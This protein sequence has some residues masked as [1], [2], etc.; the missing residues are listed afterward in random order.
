M[1]TTQSR[2]ADAQLLGSVDHLWAKDRNFAFE[3]YGG[4]AE[5]FVSETVFALTT[6]RQNYTAEL[7]DL[8]SNILTIF[9]AGVYLFCFRS[10]VTMTGGGAGQVAISLQQDPATGT[11]TSIIS[12]FNYVY[13][14]PALN[15]TCQIVI[16]LLVGFDYRYRIVGIRTSGAGNVQTLNQSNNL[17]VILMLNNK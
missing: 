4:G 9:E 2:N 8:S 13:I 1:P 16:P 12:T 17:S 14:P 6:V 11:F 15:S 10:T 3:A 5:N 7:Y